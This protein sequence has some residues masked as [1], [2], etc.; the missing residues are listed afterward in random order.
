MASTTIADLQSEVEYLRS[1][2]EA[3]G[4]LPKRRPEHAPDYIAFG[5]ARHAALLGVVEVE[6]T[7][8]AKKD[9]YTLY[10]S[11]TSGK[12]YRLED[13][14]G[15]MH[16]YPGI[17]PKQAFLVVLRQKVSSLESGPPKVP[18]NAPA[19]FAPEGYAG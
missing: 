9:G 15:A 7:D 12:T 17:E 19:M 8:Q 6:N 5:S 11:P 2:V 3:A 4:L 13:E 18:A 14:M 16:F 1:L 10:V